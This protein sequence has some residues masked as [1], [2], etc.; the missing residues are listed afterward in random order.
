MLHIYEA[1]GHN[2]ATVQDRRRTLRDRRERFV[3]LA[4]ARTEKA[5]NAIRLLGNLSNKTNYD[6]NEADAAQIVKALEFEI[7]TLKA[8]FS[9]SSDGRQ[10]TFK[11]KQRGQR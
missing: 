2:I 6:Y 7:K 11:L 9:E 5:L 10:N 3:S 4:E 1:C 8:K